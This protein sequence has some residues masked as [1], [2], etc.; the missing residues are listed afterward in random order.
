M[1]LPENLKP[2]TRAIWGA[3]AEPFWERATQV[4]VSLSV[5]FQYETVDELMDVVL[6]KA[7]GHIYARNT[8]PTVSVLEK[9]LVGL[10]GGAEACTSFSTGM[11]GISNTLLNVPEARRSMRLH[12]R[13]IRR[14]RQAVSRVPSATPRSSASSAIRPMKTRSWPRSARDAPFC[15]LNPPPTPR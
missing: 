15:T 9:K 14:H 6:G 7:P 1:T 4:P 11:G 2:S 5:S 12:R 13:H 10:E 3:E 8:N